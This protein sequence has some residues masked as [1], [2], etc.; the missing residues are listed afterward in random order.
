VKFAVGFLV[1][2][3]ARIGRIAT[4]YRRDGRIISIYDSVILVIIVGLIGLLSL[5]GMQDL[6]FITGLI[7]GMLLIQLFFHRF[8]KPLAPEQSPESGAAPRKVMS[9]AI[10]AQPGLAWREILVMTA[11]FGWALYA[12]LGQLL[13]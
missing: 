9:Y 11:L 5:T 7:V 12:L 2:Y 4:Y 8:D 6:S 10:Q 3:Q 13:T 1:P